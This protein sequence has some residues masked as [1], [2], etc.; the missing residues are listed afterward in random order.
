MS[1]M[2][3]LLAVVVATAICTA[4][5]AATPLQKQATQPM[6]QQGLIRSWPFAGTPATPKRAVLE[7]GLGAGTVGI[8]G[9]AYGNT[10][11]GG[12]YGPSRNKQ[13][14]GYPGGAVKVFPVV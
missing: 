8:L 2:A 7:V 3:A 5:T 4:S 14:G 1:R 9:A 13:A 10:P 12:A 11:A 6:G